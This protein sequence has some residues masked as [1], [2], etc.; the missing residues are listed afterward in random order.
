VLWSADKLETRAIVRGALRQIDQFGQKK[1]LRETTKSP[2]APTQAGS[3]PE[4]GHFKIKHENVIMG[5][6]PQHQRRAQQGVR[7][8]PAGGNLCG[9]RFGNTECDRPYGDEIVW[10]YGDVY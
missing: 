8:Q 1:P 6:C 5:R 9:E 10:S 3:D 4:D 7:G 2:S